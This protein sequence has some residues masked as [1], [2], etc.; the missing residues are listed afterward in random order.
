MKRRFFIFLLILG[1]VISSP[2]FAEEAKDPSVELARWSV[3]KANQ[4][5]AKQPWLVGCNFIPS[6]AINQL[7]MWQ[8]ETFDPE[9]IDKELGW[10]SKLGFNVVR[11][12]LHDLA[13]AQDSRGFLK[14]IER[15]LG[16]ADSHGIKVIFVIFDDCWLAEPKAGKQ[17]E[18]WAG[19]HNSGW[20]ESPGLEQLKR[21]KTDSKLRHRLEN[22]ARGVMRRFGNDDRV[23]MWDL[24]N[25]PG[26]WWYRRG[27]KPGDF[28]KGLTNELCLPLLKDAYR[29]ARSVNPKQPLTSCWNRGAFEVEAALNWADVV[30]FH[31]YG[32]KESLENLIGKLKEGS[33]SRP[34]VCTEYLARARGDTF[35]NSLPVLARHDIGAVNWGLVSGKT[36]TIWAWASWST[37]GTAE[38][39]VWHH[40]ILRKD[41]TAFDEKEAEFIR[42]FTKQV[43][44][45]K[46]AN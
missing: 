34:I 3:E 45:S 35:E 30:T 12:Y 17:P 22:Y 6:T 16:I 5:Y 39:E 9:T 7:E 31:H 29:W 25:E 27:E 36:N 46:Q 10:A 1:A 11:V 33:P 41:G 2:V 8:E 23:L 13:Y 40:D 21:Y 37:P 26:G 15:F 42:S 24:Y 4:W 20:L 28:S 19:V 43:R 14:R 32:N 38:P 18:P 44:E